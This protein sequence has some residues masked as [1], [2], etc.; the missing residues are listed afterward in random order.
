M[1]H[2]I[3]SKVAAGPPLPINFL[4]YLETFEKKFGTWP[5]TT[6]D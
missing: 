4:D 2:A 3:F 6:F 5:Y 1:E